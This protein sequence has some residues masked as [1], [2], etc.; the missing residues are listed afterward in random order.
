MKRSAK[1]PVVD[2]AR[3]KKHEYDYDES[4]LPPHPEKLNSVVI[5]SRKGDIDARVNFSTRALGC[6]VSLVLRDH[7]GELVR[8]IREHSGRDKFVLGA[9]A[10]LTNVVILKEL[11]A[12]VDKGTYVRFIVQKEDFLRPDYVGVAPGGE[13]GSRYWAKKLQDLY[14][15][16][17][18]GKPEGWGGPIR[19]LYQ[20]V[21]EIASYVRCVDMA[22]VRCV[23]NHNS[24]KKVA[25]PRM[26]NKFVLFGELTSKPCYLYTTDEKGLIDGV[27]KHP[28]FTGFWSETKCLDGFLGMPPE[29]LPRRGFSWTPQRVWTGSFNFTTTSCFSLENAVVIRNNDIAK[30][31]FKE[32]CLILTL[33]EPL[34]W[35]S[36]WVLPQLSAGS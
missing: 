16:L 19:S 27:G 28:N 12:A 33:S 25:F 20:Q 11:A 1:K 14:G 29:K 4:N 34:D 5:G 3:L 8:L 30:A 24:E 36:E 15:A 22:A 23:G 31:Y 32:F 35:A 6:D 2:K 9:V 18:R 13:Q 21:N 26:H 10:W 7:E 17:D